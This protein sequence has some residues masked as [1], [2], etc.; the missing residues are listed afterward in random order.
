MG[1]NGSTAFSSSTG[2]G[3]II[4]VNSYLDT[5]NDAVIVMNIMDYSATDK[6]KTAI[7]SSDKAGAGATERFVARWA[8]TSAITSVRLLGVGAATYAA[9]S[10]FALYGVSA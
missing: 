8:N 3:N 2:T 4:A 9:G 1:G 7:W 6:H 10:T 5:T